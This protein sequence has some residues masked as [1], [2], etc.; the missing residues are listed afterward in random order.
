MAVIK[1][2]L[3]YLIGVCSIITLKGFWIALNPIHGFVKP[4][5]TLTVDQNG[6]KSQ[7]G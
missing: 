3:S 1:K 2:P 6:N 5:S 7:K 4:K